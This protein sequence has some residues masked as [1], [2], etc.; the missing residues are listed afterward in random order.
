LEKD[1]KRRLRDIGDARLEIEDTLNKPATAGS[2]AGANDDRG[3]RTPR[4]WMA[5]LLAGGVI[6]GAAIATLVKTRPA[7]SIQPPAH[8]LISVPST[9][10]V[11]GL[12][13]P[14]VAI[15]S[16]ASLIVYVA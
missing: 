2:V 8:F 1:L 12:D 16:D 5:G 9:E 7:A 3:R 15:S 10:R 11:A 4:A 6:A 13:F 14:A